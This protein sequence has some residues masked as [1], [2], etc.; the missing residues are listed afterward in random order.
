MGLRDLRTRRERAA[1]GGVPPRLQRLAGDQRGVVAIFAI[2]FSAIFLAVAVAIDYART[3]TEVVRGQNAL[4]ATVLAASHRPGGPTRMP[5]AAKM[6]MLFQGEHD[7]AQGRG[8]PEGRGDGRRSGR[9]RRSGQGN[10]LTSLLKAVGIKTI[11]LGFSAT[12]KKGRSRVEVALVL[13]NSGSMAGQPISDLRPGTSRA[14]FSATRAP[15]KSRSASCPSPVPSTLARPIKARPGS[16][17]AGVAGALRKLRRTAYASAVRRAGH[18]LGRLRR[19]PAPTR[20][21][22][23]S[24]RTS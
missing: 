11:G 1:P 14:C 6:P 3:Q 17:A 8:R 5:P 18:E 13:D 9:G 2:T 20:V 7:Q 10:M 19:V 23:R 12:V 4:D 21:L 22:K 15:T 24:H 16:I